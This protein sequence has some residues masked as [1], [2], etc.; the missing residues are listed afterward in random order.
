MS[1]AGCSAEVRGGSGRKDGLGAVGCLVARGG[2][3]VE[4]I[5]V[6]ISRSSQSKSTEG[7]GTYRL[8]GGGG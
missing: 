2:S 3:K 8:R 5:S 1:N 6:S 4:G 7:W